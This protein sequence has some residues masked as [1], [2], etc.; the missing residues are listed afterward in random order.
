MVLKKRY[1]AA[2][3][4]ADELFKTLNTL[5]EIKISQVPGGSNIFM[6]SL[7]PKIDSR[8][9]SESLFSKQN[10]RFASSVD[11]KGQIRV[12]VNESISKR[13]NSEL[14]AAFKTAVV[15]GRK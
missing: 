9:L 3:Q 6:A 7:S 11:S 8:K 12:A 10:I 2:V 15:D 14:V 1:K 4:Q 13:S 5:P